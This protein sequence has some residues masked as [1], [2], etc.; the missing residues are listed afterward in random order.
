MGGIHRVYD[1]DPVG[2]QPYLKPGYLA[3]NQCRIAQKGYL[4][5]IQVGQLPG[6]PQDARIGT[7]RQYY[8]LPVGLGPFQQVKLE[9]PGGNPAAFKSS[10][11]FS[12]LINRYIGLEILD[13]SQDFLRI[14]GIDFRLN[15]ADPVRNIEG[16]ALNRN[17][18]DHLGEA[19][20]Q[21]DNGFFRN[22]AAGKDYAR[23]GRVIRGTVCL[24]G[25]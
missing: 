24:E 13:G 17:N 14:A 19:F 23:D 18:G 7:L 3:R 15:V 25:A 16:S 10:Q 5:R 20:N 9:H 22:K 1:M 8:M 2:I 11:F 12:K 4:R 21:P 6:C